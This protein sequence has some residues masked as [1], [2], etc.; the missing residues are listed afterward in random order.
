ML[1][2][3][4]LVITAASAQDCLSLHGSKLCPAFATAQVYK[5]KQTQHKFEQVSDLDNFINASLLSASTENFNLQTG[6]DLQTPVNI[7]F[8]QEALCATLVDIGVKVYKCA[9]SEQPGPICK[10]STQQAVKAL[11]LIYSDPSKCPEGKPTERSFYEDMETYSSGAST[12][13]NCIN[14]LPGNSDMTKVEE[15]NIENSTPDLAAASNPAII[16][17]AVGSVALIFL[18]GFATYFLKNRGKQVKKPLNPNG[19]YKTTLNQNLYKTTSPPIAFQNG[20]RKSEYGSEYN[21]R[22]SNYTDAYENHY[23][24]ARG[25]SGAADGNTSSENETAHVK[26]EYTALVIIHFLTFFSYQMN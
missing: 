1:V 13:S 14:S 20:N 21:H 23:S 3:A 17:G 25:T 22:E 7:P 8:L 6:C 19:L 2:T 5:G 16:G 10:S 9:A 15:S 11:N 26:H 18:I 4:L 24:T 12:A